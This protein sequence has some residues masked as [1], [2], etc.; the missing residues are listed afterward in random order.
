[1]SYEWF[2]T[3]DY[4]DFTLP[5]GYYSSLTITIGRGMGQNWWCVMYPPMCLD[6]AL[7]D[8]SDNTDNYTDN[9][10]ALIS[11]GRYSVKFKVLELLSKICQR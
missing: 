3:R 4:G 5:C 9:E 1:M 8:Q 6:I 7:A 2:D 11:N 10:N